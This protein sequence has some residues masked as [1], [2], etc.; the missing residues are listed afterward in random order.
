M[1]N[2]LE[3]MANY[4]CALEEVLALTKNRRNAYK[5]LKT[6]EIYYAYVGRHDQP[7]I[8]DKRPCVIAEDLGEEIRVY[9]LTSKESPK[10]KL[11]YKIKDTTYA[12]VKNNSYIRLEDKPYQIKKTWVTS[13]IGVLSS[14]D[15]QEVLK[16][17]KCKTKDSRH[18]N[19]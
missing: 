4:T 7:G 15:L 19:S 1:K 12:N 9:K 3:E 17:L 10:Q 5:N 13:Y 2:K 11:R 18:T 14:E 8:Y 6:F 16:L